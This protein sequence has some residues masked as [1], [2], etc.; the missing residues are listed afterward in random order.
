MKSAKNH[1]GPP[2]GDIL[3]LFFQQFFRCADE[4][5]TAFEKFEI[6]RRWQDDGTQGMPLG[7][8]SSLR[9]V[10]PPDGYLSFERFCAGLQIS[11][12]RNKMDDRPSTSSSS[13]LASIPGLTASS[14]SSVSLHTVPPQHAR[15]LSAPILDQADNNQFR[16]QSRASN[17]NLQPMTRKDSHQQQ[18]H[19]QQKQQQSLQH[20]KSHNKLERAMSGPLLDEQ[21]KKSSYDY[22]DPRGLGPK[23]EMKVGFMNNNHAKLSTGSL[24]GPPKPPRVVEQQR[25]IGE[26]DYGTS[27]LDRNQEQR[28]GYG[29]PDH[30]ADSQNTHSLD[31]DHRNDGGRRWSHERPHRER[32]KREKVEPS[33]YRS[34]P[35]GG[36]LERMLD[37]DKTSSHH[38]LL[39]RAGIRSVLQTWHK[40]RNK[41]DTGDN[42]NNNRK[43]PENDFNK[44]HR[45]KTDSSSRYSSSVE[46]NLYV[47]GVGDGGDGGRTLSS[48][49][50]IS[51]ATDTMTSAA[52]LPS[53]SMLP[54]N[55]QAVNAQPGNGQKKRDRRR[56]ARRHTLQNG[57]DFNM[58]RR[59]KELEAERDM[60]VQGYEIVEKA[61]TWYRQQLQ[62]ITERIHNMPQ[63]PPQHEPTQ[64]AQ[65]EKLHFQL[66]RIY[67]VN[68]HL[69][70]LMECSEHGLQ[71]HMNLAIRTHAANGPNS[72]GGSFATNKPGSAGA[73]KKDDEKQLSRLKDQNLL[74]TEEVSQKSERISAL[75]RE[76]A[77]LLRELFQ[78]R[79][80]QQLKQPYASTADTTFM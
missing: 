3:P 4:N 57:I 10:T 75:E 56:E 41:P 30:M 52:S 79:S 39:G 61:R 65:Q 58:L 55:S 9:K 27:S 17:S 33:E 78:P 29:E 20:H 22:N 40:E 26:S 51:S 42:N 43:I 6:E 16:H 64:E 12:L 54:N 32:E 76:K 67:E 28:S 44:E 19:Q 59:I 63:S 8:L 77:A 36:S 50:Q 13:S 49:Q 21:V 46:S 37:D 31:R 45:P 2:L 66:A 71:P 23:P 5:K 48:N 69:Q 1:L 62:S 53:S 7:V 60:L 80:T 15:P 72:V 24:S 38:I 18:P 34:K 47:R 11:L 68:T 14:S 73:L 35:R 70:A 25:D 74:L